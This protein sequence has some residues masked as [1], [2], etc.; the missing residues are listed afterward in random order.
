[1]EVIDITLLN[2]QEEVNFNFEVTPEEEDKSWELS[3]YFQR[4]DTP[5]DISME[6]MLQMIKADREQRHRYWN[7]HHYHVMQDAVLFRTQ[8]HLYYLYGSCK[9]VISLTKFIGC[10]FKQFDPVKE[11]ERMAKSKTFLTRKHQPSYKYNGCECAEDI[12]SKWNQACFLGSDFHRNVEYFLNGIPWEEQEVHPENR[13]CQQQFMNLFSDKEFWEWDT[14]W[15]EQPL[16]YPPALLAGSPD[17]IL[18]S[19]THPMELVII[20]IKRCEALDYTTFG[21]VSY[22]H[23]PCAHI[24]NTKMNTYGLQQSGL[25]WMLEQY[26]YTVRHMFLLNVHPEHDT[27]R[28]LVVQD[29]GPEFQK[30]VEYRE[31]LLDEHGIKRY[32]GMNSN[33]RQ[34]NLPNIFNHSIPDSI[35]SAEL[36]ETVLI[37]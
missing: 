27:A 37:S 3:L 15:T 17:I 5:E 9:H 12:R 23:G 29:F 25:K 33:I 36:N 34:D 18:K 28:V 1:M 4:E 8:G 2:E 10:F 31:R 14:F 20:D 22:G 32:A 11:S 24:A 7:R 19:K 30:M 13:S 26:G 6:D 21:N 16:C 35:N